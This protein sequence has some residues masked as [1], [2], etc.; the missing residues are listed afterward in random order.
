MTTAAIT[1]LTATRLLREQ[2]QKQRLVE[3]QRQLSRQNQ[4]NNA[5][6]QKL[7]YCVQHVKHEVT[8]NKK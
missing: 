2:S 3:K 1:C 4:G 6:E 5:K 8:H 7:T